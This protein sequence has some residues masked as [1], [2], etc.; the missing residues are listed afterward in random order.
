M[1]NNL[2]M[3]QLMQAAINQQQQVQ[4]RRALSYCEILSLILVLMKCMGFIACS[5]WVP[6]APLAI[7]VIVWGAV[8]LL[9]FIRTKFFKN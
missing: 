4:Q 1:N 5:W 2:N 9:G 7:P 3:N 6:F 8:L